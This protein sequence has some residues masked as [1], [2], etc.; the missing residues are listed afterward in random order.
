M[1]PRSRPL[2][3]S[4]SR[5]WLFLGGLHSCRACLRFTSRHHLQPTGCKCKPA[6]SAGEL[7]DGTTVDPGAL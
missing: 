6:R 2:T 1:R 3:V 4:M 7:C 5:S